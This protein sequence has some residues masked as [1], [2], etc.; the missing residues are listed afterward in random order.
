MPALAP[1]T[2]G[3]SKAITV[4]ATT[5]NLALPTG[6][7]QVMITSIAANAIVYINFG[8][9]TVTAVAPTGTASASFPVLPGTTP[10]FTIPI[11]A[12][13]IATIGT[14]PNPLV[15]TRGDGQ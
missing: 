1:F 9:S 15:V 2:P 12:T 13:H 11:G 4:A 14:S 3:N 5:A 8:D 7:D 6:G 10:I